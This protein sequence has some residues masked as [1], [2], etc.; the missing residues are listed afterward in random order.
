[1]TCPASAVAVQG[2]GTVLGFQ[3]G[4]L[5]TGLSFAAAETHEGVCCEAHWRFVPR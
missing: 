3:G 1:M 4:L 2:V 5:Q